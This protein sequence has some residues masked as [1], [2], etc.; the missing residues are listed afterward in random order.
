MNHDTT[1]DTTD[2]HIDEVINDSEHEGEREGYVSLGF[3]GFHAFRAPDASTTW[4]DLADLEA[5]PPEDWELVTMLPSNGDDP[6]DEELRELAQ[7]TLWGDV[8]EY[9]PS[10]LHVLLVGH[11]DPTEAKVHR[12]DPEEVIEDE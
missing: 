3:Y 7:R 2:D 12:F 9:D 11:G 5:F 4:E 8:Q 1:D 10:R 6:T